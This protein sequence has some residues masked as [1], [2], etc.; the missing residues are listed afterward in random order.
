M[1]LILEILRC[2][3]LEAGI[4]AYI[5]RY[6]VNKYINMFSLMDRYGMHPQE[7]NN[8]F[9]PFHYNVNTK[10]AK[11]YKDGDQWVLWCFSERKLFTSWDVY[12]LLN[13][14]PYTIAEA[15][16]EKLNKEQQDNIM[17]DLGKE[18][19]VTEV[20]YKEALEK[21]RAGTVS[22]AEL[23]KEVSNLV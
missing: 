12:E 7:I 3:A 22:Y 18:Q 5:A 20:P 15:I 9:C 19:E 1:T 8:M 14:N 10:A 6:L 2:Y 23:C 16:W 17:N 4:N 13:I 11:M 21:F